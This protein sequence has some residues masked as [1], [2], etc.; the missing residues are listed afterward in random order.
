MTRDIQSITDVFDAIDPPLWVVTAASRGLRGGLIA[1]FVSK[2][3]IVPELPRVLVGLSVRHFTTELVEA[4]GVFALHLLR[5]DQ[6]EWVERFGLTSGRTLDKFVGCSLVDS[7][8]GPPLLLE[9]PARL[10]C[11]VE[12][13]LDTG[14]RSIYLA[15][16][17]SGT[18]A[19]SGPSVEPLTMRRAAQHLSPETLQ[20]LRE[21]IH[22]DAKHD[23]ESILAWRT[24]LN[25]QP[26]SK[27]GRIS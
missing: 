21:Q 19:A 1:T 26:I 18:I 3:S 25:A 23:S 22:E 15:A 17:E 6:F 20:R 14:D 27:E 16:V 4:S 10:V 9:A 12:G 7:F 13:K 5:H 24:N 2:A 11:R 8:D